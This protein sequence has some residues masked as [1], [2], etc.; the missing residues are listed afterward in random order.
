MKAK[1]IRQEARQ[2]LKGKWQKA[3]IISIIYAAII[4]LLTLLIEKVSSIFST[5]QL[6]ITPALTY[7]IA[8]SYWHLKKGDEVGYVDFITVGFKNFGRAWGIAWEIVKKTWWCII[9][10][11]I[12]LIVIIALIGGTIFA[13]SGLVRI[14]AYNSGYSYSGSTRSSY[15]YDYDYSDYLDNYRSN[16]S[17][18]YNT[19][20]LTAEDMED[21]LANMSV[22]A[23]IGIAIAFI[24]YIVLAIFVSIRFLL[25]VLSYYIAVI[26][27]DVSPKDAVLE[28]A[29]LM[30]GNRWRYFCLMLSFFGWFLLVGV[31]TGVVQFIN[32]PIISTIVAEIGTAILNP[33]IAFTA[34]IFYEALSKEKNLNG[35]NQNNIAENNTQNA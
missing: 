11:I 35:Q 15:Q 26:K 21:L 30:K 25:Y 16:Y 34:I 32:V 14:K 18:N 5:V 4:F 7:G 3:I 22:G 12:P 13:S 2:N 8:Y 1:E 28:S 10:F 29:D 20:N 24:V 19:S 33:Y 6:V 27:E 9:L 17:S 31:A 23:M